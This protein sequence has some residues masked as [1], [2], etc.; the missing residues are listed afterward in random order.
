MCFCLAFLTAPALAQQAPELFEVVDEV[1]VAALSS[2]VT[3][4]PVLRRQLVRVNTQA[5]DANGTSD[6]PDVM[7]NL[8]PDVRY[9]F[10]R[11]GPAEALRGGNF[12]WRAVGGDADPGYA[13]L[14]IGE[15]G[16]RGSISDGAGRHF[17]IL[18]LDGQVQ[19]IREVSAAIPDMGDDYVLPELPQ[20]QAARA[21][22]LDAEPV[23]QQSGPS[24]VDVLVVY[25]ANARQSVG[26]AAN[27]QALADVVMAE[28]NQAFQA[29]AI[30]ARVRLARLQEVPFPNGE[31]STSAFLSALRTN[32]A[33]R[34]LRDQYGADVVTAWIDGTAG[35]AGIGYVMTQVSQSFAPWAYSVV[36]VEWVDGPLYAFAH[37]A[38]HN[39]GSSHD[40]FTGCDGGALGYSCGYQQRL[41]TPRFHTIMAYQNGCT[42]CPKIN[43]F[44]NPNVT[45]QGIPTGIASGPDSADNGRTFNQTAPVASQFRDAVI[46]EVSCDLSG[47]DAVN[48]IDVQLSVNQILGLEACGT[49]DISQDGACNVVDVQRLINA[50]LGLGCQVGT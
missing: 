15:H 40:R 3:G 11:A 35:S 32:T 14:V 9:R 46:S 16:V 4:P 2:A 26:G 1:S 17:K 28:M 12:L 6:S 30:N 50:A 41:Q 10:R 20:E 8:F 25:S 42:Q 33:I 38:G 37:E 13:V 19:E 45:H 27:M 23:A 5:L 39:F 21:A 36:E 48:V 7:L 43:H 22:L 49:A 24:I 31:S 18:P 34:A 47:D 29:S 44:S